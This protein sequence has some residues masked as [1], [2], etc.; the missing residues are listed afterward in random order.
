MIRTVPADG[1]AT[2]RFF[3]A[4]LARGGMALNA[5]ETAKLTVS[6]RIGPW[7]PAEAGFK[8]RPC[9]PCDG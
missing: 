7:D 3:D 5:N 9:G 6:F 4:R 8:V 2:N 1:H